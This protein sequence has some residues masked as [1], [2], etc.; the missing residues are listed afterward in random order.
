MSISIVFHKKKKK[1]QLHFLKE[2][3]RPKLNLLNVCG[4]QF[5]L[6]VQPIRLL[7]PLFLMFVPRILH[8]V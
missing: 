2:H 4:I 7:H 6:S 1:I 5:Y 3:F 8:C